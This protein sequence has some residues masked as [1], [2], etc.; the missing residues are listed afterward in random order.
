MSSPSLS[1]PSLAAGSSFANLLDPFALHISRWRDNTRLLELLGPQGHS[2][3]A[4]FVVNMMHI[5]PYKATEGLLECAGFA[6]RPGG[7]VFAYGPFNQD[8]KFT[9]EGNRNFDRSLRSMSAEYGIR[10]IAEVSATASHFGLSLLRAHPMPAN[11]F[12]LVFQKPHDDASIDAALWGLR[13][14]FERYGQAQVFA[15]F[16]RDALSLR[17]KCMFHDNVRAVD[18]QVFQSTVKQA[19]A[20]LGPAPKITPFKSVTLKSNE[21][22]E[23]QTTWYS[24]PSWYQVGLREVARNRVAVLLMAGGQGT[25]LG[26]TAP[27]GCYD[28]LL[29]SHKSIF[30]ILA[31]KLTTLKRLAVEKRH[32]LQVKDLTM[33][34]YIMTSAATHHATVD[35]FAEHNYF[36]FP[37]EDV[38]FFEQLALPCITEQGQMFLG[39]RTNLA[40]S[41]NGNGGLFQALITGGVLDDMQARRIEYAHVFGIDNVLVKPADPT[42]V[43]FCVD[44]K[45]DCGNKVVLKEDPHEKV[46]VMA[47]L[48]GHPGVVEYSDI[49]IAQA[50]SRDEDGKLLFSA[51]NIAQHFFTLDFL[52]RAAMAK[53]PFHL[54]HKQIP[55]LNEQ[56]QLEKPLTNN[57][58][59]IE[60]FIF[61]SFAL[62]RKMVCLAVDRHE[63]FSAVKNAPGSS[64]DCP[65]TARR[66]M[67]RFW[68]SQVTAAGGIINGDPDTAVLEV[69]PT[70]SYQ[71]ENLTHSVSGKTFNLPC[72]IQ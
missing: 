7:L 3:D 45:A 59:K 18:L 49:S 11:N 57:G 68:A 33:P 63:E 27:K 17:E 42:F 23:R 15:Q 6:L 60:M 19:L 50:E 10:D 64:S 29:P 43:G 14:E 56:G 16:E 2:L 40:T 9:S 31:E 53:L 66:D 37:R 58:I 21:T 30:Q 52:K 72:V 70:L 38:R 47:L 22:A 32:P 48:N 55:F 69:S 25:R 8:G 46:G 39:S 12:I 67:S 51:G 28:I 61:D 4:L 1:A 24:R 41:P 62:A 13:A 65:D 26:S 34:W 5:S 36:G 44:Q 71:G 54:A 35:F 20:P